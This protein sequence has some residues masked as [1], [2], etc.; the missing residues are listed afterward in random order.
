MT[1][2][3]IKIKTTI[4][5][6]FE[7]SPKVIYELLNKLFLIIYLCQYEIYYKKTMGCFHFPFENMSNKHT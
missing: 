4:N 7:H 2:L 3:C 6:L 5:S 1:E